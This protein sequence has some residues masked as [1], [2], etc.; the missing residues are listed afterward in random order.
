MLL[1]VKDNHSSLLTGPQRDKAVLAGINHGTDRTSVGL[2]T[3]DYDWAEMKVKLCS[4]IIFS[5]S[6]YRGFYSDNMLS[7]PRIH[8]SEANASGWKS[9]SGPSKYAKHLRI[10]IYFVL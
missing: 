4:T 2:S 8:D 9:P 3:Q 1:F 6:L 10:L 7:K 5:K